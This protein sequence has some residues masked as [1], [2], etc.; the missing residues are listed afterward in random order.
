MWR[1]FSGL[2]AN[3][4]EQFQEQLLLE[5]AENCQMF[6]TILCNVQYLRRQ[7]RAFRGNSEERNL[8]N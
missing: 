2:S 7:G 3:K 8:V 6:V 5:K 1:A 4:D